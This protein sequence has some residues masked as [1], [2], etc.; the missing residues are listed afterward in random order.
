MLHKI[1][2][3]RKINFIK[4]FKSQFQ[5]L[6]YMSA[7]WGKLFCYTCFFWILVLY[8]RVKYFAF[9]LIC[10]TCPYLKLFIYREILLKI[11]G[12]VGNKKIFMTVDL[13][14]IYKRLKLTWTWS[15]LIAKSFEGQLP[16]LFRW[17]I[18]V[19]I[20]ETRVLRVKG[21]LFS[22]EMAHNV[23][24]DKQNFFVTRTR[25]TFSIFIKNYKFLIKMKQLSLSLIFI[26]TL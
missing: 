6:V 18:C 26:Y 22:S 23:I 8:F 24:N 19:R 14:I 20:K 9:W 10:I 1:Y 16:Y 5:H 7:D 13:Q 15:L 4:N 25:W 3:R 11:N 21:Y 2:D 17:E 12:F